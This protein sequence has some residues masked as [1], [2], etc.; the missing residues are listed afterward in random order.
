MIYFDHAASSPEFPEVTERVSELA[1]TLYWNPAARHSGGLEAQQSIQASLR[2]LA[3]DLGCR[4]EQLVVTSSA[5]ESINTAFF[6]LGMAKR[7]PKV[8]YSKVNHA[9][10]LQAGRRTMHW[11]FEPIELPIDVMTH[12]IKDLSGALSD[13]VAFVSLL[14]VNNVTGAIADLKAQV[15]LIRHRAPQ[16]LIHVDMVQMWQK[17]PIDFSSLDVD[18]ASFSGHKIRAPKGVGLLYVKKPNTFH[19]LLVGGGQQAG[20]RSG[21]EN[22]ILLGGMA[23]AITSWGKR[24]HFETRSL[25]YEALKST[26]FSELDRR[27]LAYVKHEA[28]TSSPAIVN[29]AL[30]GTRGETLVNFLGTYGIYVSNSSACSAGTKDGSYVLKALGIPQHQQ[31]ASLRVSFDLMNTREEVVEFVSALAE[32]MKYF[33]LA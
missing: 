7:R 31:L 29:F 16:A 12:G 5:T 27:S 9:A 6:N 24:G 18:F 26:L 25:G 1:Q 23:E 32:A 20:M 19:A 13:D 22:P 15:S 17:I 2:V 21:T 30:E 4:P 14:A 33:R 8:L 10:V 3:D 11:G 28:E